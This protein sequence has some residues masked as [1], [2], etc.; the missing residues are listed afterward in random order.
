MRPH[1]IPLKHVELE[2]GLSTLGAGGLVARRVEPD[3]SIWATRGFAL[4]RRP[5]GSDA[6]QFEVRLPCPLTATALLHSALVRS[7][8]RTYD[9]GQPFWLSSG[10]LLVSRR[11][12]RRCGPGGSTPRR[13]RGPAFSGLSAVPCWALPVW[14]ASISRPCRQGGATPMPIPQAGM[15][16]G[17]KSGPS[18]GARGRAA[19]GRSRRRAATGI[20]P[21]DAT[22]HS[23]NRSVGGSRVGLSYASATWPRR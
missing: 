22:D 8:L 23:R 18:P 19:D 16:A 17:P 5:S 11:R 2:S 3:G 4:Y 15:L 9:V 10:S 14:R 21:A 7:Y 13:G 20:R 12:L 1:R 6:F